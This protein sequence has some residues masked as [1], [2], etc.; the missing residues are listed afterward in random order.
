MMFAKKFHLITL[1]LFS[2]GNA[3]NGAKLFKTRCAQCHV[4]EAVRAENEGK[5][6]DKKGEAIF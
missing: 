3:V 5:A 4:V 1:F 2:P 6:R